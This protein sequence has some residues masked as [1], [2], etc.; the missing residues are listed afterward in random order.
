MRR[1]TL[2]I[3]REHSVSE[4]QAL[5]SA[6]FPFLRIKFFKN[7][8]KEGKIVGQL[9]AF[10][11]ET[12]MKEMNP[13]FSDGEFEINDEMTI[14]ELEAKFFKQFGLFVQIDRKIGNIWM[15][16]NMTSSWTL[17]K[18]NEHGRDISNED[19]KRIFF[20][21]VSFGC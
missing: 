1:I 13:E 17:R 5:F 7:R 18:Q 6:Q 3:T 16:P 9:A 12:R 15:E 19:D 10:S 4:V 20:R 11:P 14:P 8:I 21:D 2:Y